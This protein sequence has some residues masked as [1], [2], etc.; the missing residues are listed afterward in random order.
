MS[1]RNH[2]GQRSPLRSALAS[3]SVTGDRSSLGDNHVE[4]AVIA[5]NK[6]CNQTVAKMVDFRP[7]RET[8]LTWL[9]DDTTL[10]DLR[11]IKGMVNPS[12]T[13]GYY[14]SLADNVMLTMDF[15]DLSVPT[16]TSDTQ[17]VNPDRAA[18]LLEAIAEIKVIHEQFEVTKHVLRWLNRNATP[19]AIRYYF[20]TVLALCPTTPALAELQ[21]TPARFLTP[22]GIGE[23]LPLI[24]EAANVAASAAMLERDAPVRPRDRVQLQFNPYKF[25]RLPVGY[26]VDGGLGSPEIATDRRC[27]NL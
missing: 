21:N 3:G 23:Q 26:A 19:G 2:R 5:L 12:N 14:Y 27:Y 24:R 20:P 11:K 9:F 13:N 8:L 16:I 4:T 7:D 18:P 22:E 10:A 17:R 1:W 6:M 15:T 25:R